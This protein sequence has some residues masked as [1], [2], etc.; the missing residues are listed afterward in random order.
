MRK[1]RKS[2]LS[3]IFDVFNIILMMLI[4]FICLAPIVH[5]VFASVS[6]PGQLALHTGIILKPLGFTTVGYRLI[7]NN[8]V[9][10][11]SYLNTLFYLAAGLCISMALTLL[12]GYVLSRKNLLWKNTIMFFITF[13]MFFSGGLIPFYIVVTKLGLYNTRWAVILPSAVSVFNLIIM[14]TSMQEIP[15]SLEE[16]AFI[17]G[18]G[19]LTILT[20]IM[21]PLS[22]ATIAVI[23]L[24]YAVSIWNSWFNASIFL[25]D[26]NK[27]PLQLVLKEILVAN[28]SSQVIVSSTDTTGISTDI[29]KPLVKY[30]TIV[31]SILPVLCFYPFT[32]KYFIKGVMIGSIK[33]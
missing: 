11:V 5:V 22:R 16:S 7:F 6:E 26:R 20:K 28:D 27:Y 14:R 25:T 1:Q 13:T 15:E 10:L 32:Q 3:R 23:A 33:G 24:F 12:G 17:E 4:C 29:Y 31:V 9:I 21:I 2:V 18:A 19:H 8:S 30:C